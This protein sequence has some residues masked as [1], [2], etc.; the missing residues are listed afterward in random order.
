MRPKIEAKEYT[1]QTTIQTRTTFKP[2][3]KISEITRYMKT[4]YHKMK[5]RSADDPLC[6]AL[7]RSAISVIVHG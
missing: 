5:R 4:A 3:H 1:F 6:S 2:L 7:P